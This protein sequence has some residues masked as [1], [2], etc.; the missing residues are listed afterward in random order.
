MPT[1]ESSVSTGIKTVRFAPTAVAHAEEA[2]VDKENVCFRNATPPSRAQGAGRWQ[3][4]QTPH[5]GEKRSATKLRLEALELVVERAAPTPKSAPRLP[6][7]SSSSPSS[8]AVP[9]TPASTLL[10]PAGSFSPFHSADT[11]T[12][13]A[14]AKT[15]LS[16]LRSEMALLSTS[17]QA[18]GEA[19]RHGGSF[20]TMT[21]DDSLL[22]SPA[23]PFHQERQEPLMPATTLGNESASTANPRLRRAVLLVDE[24]G[25]DQR[26]QK[27]PALRDS[28]VVQHHHQ[29]RSALRIDTSHPSDQLSTNADQTRAM[30]TPLQQPSA[31]RHFNRSEVAMQWN[32]H[33]PDRSSSTIV[34][35]AA[36]PSG[37]LCLDLSNIF[38][39]AASDMKLPQ[40]DYDRNPL[41]KPWKRPP[42]TSATTAGPPSAV[43][44]AYKVPPPRIHR[45]ASTVSKYDAVESTVTSVTNEAEQSE[46]WSEKLC[47]IF[48]QWLNYMI[49]PAILDANS[50][51]MDNP[52]VMRTLRAHQQMTSTRLK[53]LELFNGESMRATR[54]TLLAEIQ[55]GRLALRKDQNV[56]ANVVLRDRMMDLLF[57]YSTPWLRLGLETIFGESILPQNPHYLPSPRH[58]GIGASS[59]QRSSL[60]LAI[61]RFIVQC[62]LSDE[63]TLTKYSKRKCPVPSGRFE[64]EYHSELRRIVLFRLMMLFFFLDSAK[65]AHLIEYVTLFR[66]DSTIKST[67]DILLSFCRDFLSA[68]GN[69]LKHLT[70]MGLHVGFQQAPLDEIELGVTN[71]AMD[72]RDGVNL[73]RLAEIMTGAPNRSILSALRLPVKSRMQKLHNV[74][75][76]LNHLKAILESSKDYPAHRRIAP[77]HVVDGHRVVVLKLLW[78]LMAHSCFDRLVDVEQIQ[79]ETCKLERLYLSRSQHTGDSTLNEAPS[80][81]DLLFR[82][83]RAL[84]RSFGREISDLTTSFADGKVFCFVISY[85]HPLLLRAR[86]I[87]FTTN[88]LP[89]RA[90]DQE[91]SVALAN[92]RS[93]SLLANARMN[94]LGGLSQ[95][96][97]LCDSTHPPDEKTVILCLSFL[98]SRLMDTKGEI[99]SCVVIQTSY[100]KHRAR[101]LLRKKQESALKILRVWRY[102]KCDY[103]RAQSRRYSRSVRNIERFVLTHRFQLAQLREQRLYTERMKKAAI[104]LQ[105]RVV[106][107]LL[108]LGTSAYLIALVL[109]S[110]ARRF[111]AGMKH[112]SLLTQIRAA[113]FLQSRWRQFLALRWYEC[114]LERLNAATVILRTWKRYQRIS[115]V[116]YNAA[117]LIQKRWRR[118]SALLSFLMQWMD[119][120]AVQALFRRRTAIKHALQRKQAVRIIQSVIYR[121]MIRI[122]L[123]KKRVGAAVKCQVRAIW[124]FTRASVSRPCST[125][126][127]V[128]L[129]Y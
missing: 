12:P 47:E 64:V 113:V 41:S 56:A 96:I 86:Q 5:E 27:T 10:S 63:A 62:V 126:L 9:T 19:A 125:M 37:G 88:D 21:I 82:W 78:M 80:I 90:T 117:V 71:L 98:W 115:L 106:H 34:C 25:Q 111:L 73:A 50:Y 15:P 14:I 108:I 94:D 92:E 105:V 93:N 102:Q 118:F 103:F 104:V 79:A 120:V 53:A 40:Q 101:V 91:R 84:S 87:K 36:T 1:V 121:R 4:Q 69:V 18:G 109:Q 42:L 127:I 60:R 57:Q 43:K 55:R 74:G 68:E 77:H 22:V 81:K 44:P 39:N 45:E 112:S 51:A 33:I 11:G 6:P 83:C 66:R 107:L 31:N 67:K 48:T 119:I 32:H 20:A 129:V 7:S 85:Y 16:L 59:N 124:Y 49:Q 26:Q 35:T 28:T 100:R 23:K 13:A 54:S 61:K 24:L 72:L 76:A 110:Q 65:Q 89:P 2:P 116:R 3:N 70:K 38:R 122:K 97:P 46:E 29:A 99:R 30:A 114:H 17:R 8:A 75:V 58:P 52:S 128:C 95:M 123:V